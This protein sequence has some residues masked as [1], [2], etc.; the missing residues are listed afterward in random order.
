MICPVNIFV[1]ILSR[2]SWEKWHQIR[3]INPR[4]QIKIMIVWWSCNQRQSITPWFKLESKQNWR[5][6]LAHSQLHGNLENTEFDPSVC[7]YGSQQ[8]PVLL[9]CI[10]ELSH[11]SVKG[12]SRRDCLTVQLDHSSLMIAAWKTCPRSIWKSF[13]NLHC[14]WKIREFKNNKQTNEINICFQ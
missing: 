13:C 3:F 10:L 2:I 5:N 11:K 14:L 9:T 1:F 4:L 8:R 6:T 12:W 7:K